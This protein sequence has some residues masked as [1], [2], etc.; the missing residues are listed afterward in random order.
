MLSH[1]NIMG[2]FFFRIYFGDLSL[3][4]D[5]RNIKTSNPRLLEYEKRKNLMIVFVCDIFLDDSKVGEV[6]IFFSIYLY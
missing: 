6:F 3:N 5:D 4:N 2:V 1:N